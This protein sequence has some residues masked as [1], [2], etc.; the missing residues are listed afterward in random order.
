VN[1][2]PA[3]VE[4]Y[5]V[6]TRLPAPHRLSSADAWALIQGNFVKHAKVVGLPGLACVRLL[7]RLVE[8]SVSGGRSYDA[9]IGECARIGRADTLLTFN[10]RHFDPPP[11]GVMVVVPPDSG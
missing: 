7:A 11:A 10:V 1:D 4:A 8:A 3:L 2:A 6:L 5:A 9:I